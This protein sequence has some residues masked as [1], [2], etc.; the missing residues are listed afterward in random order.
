MLSASQCLN[1]RSIYCCQYSLGIFKWLL[2]IISSLY[3]S[4]D[5]VVEE[6]G[7]SF[8]NIA[9]LMKSFI[10][11]QGKPYKSYDYGKDKPE[12]F[13]DTLGKDYKFQ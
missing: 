6:V 13:E 2:E 11:F 5:F 9:K 12:A 7:G 8:N 3:K 4:F 10:A 1:R